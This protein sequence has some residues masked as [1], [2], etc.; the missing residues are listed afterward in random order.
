[1]NGPKP[2]KCWSQD[3]QPSFLTPEH[4]IYHPA[5]RYNVL[6]LSRVLGAAVSHLL[7]VMLLQNLPLLGCSLAKRSYWCSYT[8]LWFNYSSFKLMIKDLT[9]DYKGELEII[10]FLKLCNMFESVVILADNT[11]KYFWANEWKSWILSWFKLVKGT[12]Q[13]EEKYSYSPKVR[14]NW[15]M[16][17]QRYMFLNWYL[18]IY[19][20][21]LGY[22]GQGRQDEI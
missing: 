11:L 14:N 7:N 2:D 16:K 8:Y 9:L 5:R 13:M 18:G 15:V 4:V 6:I 21:T 20:L 17:C 12:A 3:Y 19:F 22:P 1:M 10:L